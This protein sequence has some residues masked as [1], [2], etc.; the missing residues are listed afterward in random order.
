MKEDHDKKKK[1]IK[2]ELN[3]EEEKLNA[4][5]ENLKKILGKKINEK[6][7]DKKKLD[8]FEGDQIQGNKK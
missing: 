6:F 3:K 5:Y 8:N 4:K 2:E 1:K 7:K